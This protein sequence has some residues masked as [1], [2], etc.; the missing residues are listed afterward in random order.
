MFQSDGGGEF[1]SIAFKNILE[2]LGIIHQL[3][4]PYTPQQNGVV[5]R[6]HIHIIEI[7]LFLMFQAH[8]PLRYWIDACSG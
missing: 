1:Q 2:K 4:F 7:G 5:E 3:S 8:M 6:K